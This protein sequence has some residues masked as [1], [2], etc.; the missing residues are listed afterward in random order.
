[1]PVDT[2]GE[3]LVVLAIQPGN[4]TLAA[5]QRLPYGLRGSELVRLAFSGRAGI[6]QGRIV[7]LDHRP[8]GDDRLDAALASLARGRRPPPAKAWVGRPGSGSCD[9]YLARLAAAG[10][11]REERDKLLGFI[12]V[13]RWRIADPARAAD[14]RARLDAI[15]HGTGEVDT[16]QAAL[17]GLAGAVLYPG[18][19]RRP[20]RKRLER[21]AKGELTRPVL[22]AARAPQAATDAA[23]Q[24][25]THA[26]VSAAVHAAHHAASDAGGHGGHGGGGGGH[27]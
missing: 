9:A 6:T 17:A 2:L 12:P 1:V 19:A 18:L 8:T 4:G 15:V 21:I 3:D 23:T 24:A 26:A 11:I 5:R 14:T 10:A 20:L 7:V 13:V 25:A 22:Q 16:A 27:H